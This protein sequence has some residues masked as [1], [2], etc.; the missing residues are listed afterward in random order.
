MIERRRF[1]ALAAASAFLPSVYS[2]NAFAQAW[3]KRSVRIV[4]PFTPGGTNDTTARI[5]APRMSE[6]WGQPVVIENKPGAGANIGIE[7]VARSMPDGYTILITPVALAV[8]RFLY[9]SL[10]YDPVADFAPVTLISLEPNIM[11]VPSTS[12]ARSVSEFIQQAKARPGGMS[13][14]SAGRGTSLHL[15][16]E[17]F[18][19]MAGVDLTHVPY[20]GS[21]PAIIDLISGRVDVMFSGATSLLPHIKAGRVRGIAVTTPKRSPAIPEL[22]TVA[23]S[24]IPGFDVSSWSAFFAPA[25]TPTEVLK[26]I[27]AGVVSVL[28]QAPL[29]AKFAEIGA[30]IVGSTPQELGAHLDSEMK[31]W[32]PLIKVAGIKSDA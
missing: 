7:A 22:P 8:N 32:G 27:H 20:R 3:P 1:L 4:V 6:L 11:A 5:L 24:G 25:R 2:R 14:G 17:M 15:C 23:E 21:A 13:Y 16:G 18:K 28:G 26:T 9:P 29:Q 19:R 31:K 12:T 10:N 30:V